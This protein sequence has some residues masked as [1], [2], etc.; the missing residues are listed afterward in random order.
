MSE[1]RRVKAS[2]H[3]SIA[4]SNLVLLLTLLLN[5]F[6]AA[7]AAAQVADGGVTSPGVDSGVTAT[8]DGDEDIDE[9]ENDVLNGAAPD[10][11]AGVADRLLSF[12]LSSLGLERDAAETPQHSVR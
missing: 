4:L 6:L 3:R 9:W 11:Q 1:Y 8:G 12:L 7:P 10:T 5:G 2:A